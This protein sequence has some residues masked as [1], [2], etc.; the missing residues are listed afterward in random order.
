MDSP[1]GTVLAIRYTQMADQGQSAN[2]MWSSDATL[3][4]LGPVRLGNAAGED[5]TPKARKTRALL[6]VLATCRSPLPR[7][8]LIHLLWGD[9]GEDQA[10]ASLRQALYELRFLTST[11]YLKADRESVMFGPKMLGTDIQ[12]LNDAIARKSSG[13]LADLLTDVELPLLG[14]LDDIT[15]EFDDWLRHERS[16]LG[17]SI[18][19]SGLVL[20]QHALETGD[21]ASARRLAD[22]LERFDPLDERVTRLGIAADLDAGDRSAAVRRHGRL[23]GHLK[24]ELGIEPATETDAMLKRTRGPAPILTARAPIPATIIGKQSPRTKI[25]IATLCGLILAAGLAWFALRTS[26]VSATPTIAVMPFDGIGSSDDNHLAAGVSDEILNLLSHQNRF[27]ILGRVSAEE[28]AHQPNLLAEARRLGITYLLDGSVQASG[29]KL[30]VIVRLTKTSDGTQLWSERYERTAGDIFD[31]QNDIA[32]AVASRMALSLGPASPQQTSPE[33]YD[34]Y[35]AA[36]Q[37]ERDRREANLVQARTLLKEAIELDNRYAPAYAELSQVT[38]LLADHPASWGE[39]PYSQAR[40]RAEAYARKAISLDPNLGDGWAAMGFLTFSDRRSEAYYA[41]AVALSPQRA[42][43]HRWYAQSLKDAH[44]YDQAIQE[45]KRAVAIDPLWGINVDHLVGALMEL[46]RTKEA[47]AYT[48]RF[49]SLSTDRRA[50]LMF[51]RSIANFDFRMAE[52][53]QY[54]REL[55]QTYP[56]ERQ[57]RFSYAS[58][59]AAIGERK[60]AIAVLGDSVEARAVLSADWG[61]LARAARADGA[62]YWDYLG[63]FWNATDLL[64]A[65]GHGDVLVSLYDQALPALGKGQVLMDSVASID[66]VLALREAGRTADADRLERFAV[67]RAQS[68]P[69]AGYAGVFRRMTRMYHSLYTGQREQGLRLLESFGNEQ[70]RQLLLLPSMSLRWMPIFRALVGDPRF[71][72]VDEKVRMSLNAQRAKAG[73]PPITREDWISDPKTLLTKN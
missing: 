30:L 38:L 63:N 34:R 61:G 28:V 33:V 29:R 4:L 25:V 41:R 62:G 57:S 50:K 48:K 46:G 70:P 3:E 37:L 27:R 73:L 17:T 16:K 64:L 55:M 67:A 8:R 26:P 52:A 11:G 58:A 1:T 59:L 43:F 60:Q 45:Y 47:D 19:D 2:L 15:P 5:L 24:S 6:A 71:E 51:L 42:D 68:V 32:N 53:L 54:S 65:S 7:S 35:L 66:T 20:G 36:R 69:D 31:I 10:K 44:K 40:A 21:L 56:D 22:Q 72:A 14:S 12:A 18:V 39:T 49:L 13:A 23:A 9:R